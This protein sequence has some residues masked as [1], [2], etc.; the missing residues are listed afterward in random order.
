MSGWSSDS[1]W[2]VVGRSSV[3]R[4]L[5]DDFIHFEFLSN[6][7]QFFLEISNFNWPGLE[8]DGS[9]GRNGAA[10]PQP[11]PI[12]NSPIR[13][14]PVGPKGVLSRLEVRSALHCLSNRVSAESLS[15]APRTRSWPCPRAAALVFS[16][17]RSSYL[18][19]QPLSQT[20][21]PGHFSLARVPTQPA[22]QSANQ[23][24]RASSKTTENLQ[25]LIGVT[26]GNFEQDKDPAVRG[27]HFCDQ[28]MV[29]LFV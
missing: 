13:F 10:V 1:R 12:E 23:V 6:S 9:D 16:L 17:G 7:F 8:R 21:S 11:W 27:A 20:G 22:S 28:G 25:Y 15:E 4:P 18:A 26:L 3:G 2:V 5:S 14:P 24:P 19:S 29:Q